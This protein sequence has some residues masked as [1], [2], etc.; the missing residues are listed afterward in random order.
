MLVMTV[1]DCPPSLRGELTRW[2]LEIRPH[3]YVGH[4]NA[5]VRDQ[6]WHKA[7]AKL[8]DGSVL[9]IWNTPSE[10]GYTLRSHGEPAYRIRDFEGVL[11]VERPRDS[12][13][14]AVEEPAPGRRSRRSRPPDMAVEA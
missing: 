2:L 1:T 14:K 8:S 7:C 5:R 3:V 11:L 6:L 4:V 9:Q 12:S 10:Q 13:P